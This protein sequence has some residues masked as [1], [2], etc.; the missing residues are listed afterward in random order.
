MFKKNS[1]YQITLIFYRLNL[2][3]EM[4]E[5]NYKFY[6]AFENSICRDY[7]TEKLYNALLFHTVPIVY[8]GADY[9]AIG[10]PSNSYI[11]VRNFNSG[12][13]TST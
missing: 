5:R 10:L 12:F 13:T 8:G 4:I 3:D 7:A 2:L 6:L 1:F 9:K 11:D